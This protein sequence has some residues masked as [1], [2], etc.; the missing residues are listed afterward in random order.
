M[1]MMMMMM[2]M[3]FDIMMMIIML[4]L[5]SNCNVHDDDGDDDD[6]EDDDD[7]DDEDDDDGYIYLSTRPSKIGAPSDSSAAVIIARSAA[8]SSAIV[9]TCASISQAI[10]INLTWSLQSL[11]CSSSAMLS[12]VSIILVMSWESAIFCRRQ[13]ILERVDIDH[14][15]CE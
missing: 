12:T 2:M 10:F 9:C 7:D 8:R 3:M 11:E 5:M 6:D 15:P 1:M 4:M 13:E 14:D